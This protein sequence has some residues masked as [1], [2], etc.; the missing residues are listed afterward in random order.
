MGYSSLLLLFGASIIPEEAH[1]FSSP[2][3]GSKNSFSPLSAVA[4]VVDPPPKTAARTPSDSYD[5]VVVGSGIG[6][7]SCAAMLSYYGYSVAVLESHYAA[8]GAAHG[9]K[10][11]HKD[12]GDFYFDTGPSFF[13]GLNPDLP[14]K[15]SNP[16]R[17]ILDVI[18][19]PVECVPYTT[20]GLKF[21]EGDFV[22]TPGFG[23]KGGTIEQI[24]G[25]EGIKSWNR[26]M[27]NMEPLAAAVH[28]LPTAA[29]RG[30]IGTAATAAPYM[31]KFATLNPLENLKLTKPFQKVL[32]N[33]KVSKPSF[34]QNWLDLLCF[35][36]SG[37]KAD[38]TITAE[39]AMMMGEFYDESAVMDCPVGG[40]KAIVDALVRGIEKHGGSIFL[41]SHVDEILIQDEKATGIRLKKG[42]TVVKANKAVVSNLSVWDLFGSGIVDTSNFPSDFVQE[43]LDT[44]VGKSF[45]HLHV[46]FKANREELEQL[47]AHYMYV[48]D[49]NKGVEG[50]DNAVLLS[51]PS[52]HDASLAPE[53][54]GVLHIYTPAT[55]DFARWENIDRKSDEYKALKEERSQYLW[56]VLEKV[57]PDIRERAVV[58]QVGSPL[59]HK[60]FLL[61]HKG[62]YGPAIVAGEESFPFPGTPVKNLLVT[63][64]S[65]FPGIGVPAVAGSGF[66]TAN[67]VSL[68][69]LRP[70]LKLLESL[71]RKQQWQ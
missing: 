41:N 39:M 57:I 35:C 49:W 13:S 69:S 43:R 60:R 61:R 70:Q 71:R 22:H 40:A 55:E 37:M 53:G 47:Q 62:S 4:N 33:S 17:T 11:R 6:G 65:C 5:V 34:M 32:D 42:D 30:D 63:G 12:V 56:S 26:L 48:D 50:E 14:A 21:P 51:I 28:A 3:Q 8:G 9:F 25:A 20:F 19:E 16:L 45:M 23:K 24:D 44:P 67:S 7:L 54:Y 66:L 10:T 18:D 2:P 52:V 64:D 27:E 36:L 15:T 1:G 58:S 46:G 31:S 68:D 38:G 29:L 59:T